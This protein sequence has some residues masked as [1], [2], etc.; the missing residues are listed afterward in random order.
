MRGCKPGEPDASLPFAPGLQDTIWDLLDRC[1]SVSADE[2]PQMMEVE[3]A[4]E[5]YIVS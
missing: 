3:V 5:E 4:L 2:R 1:W